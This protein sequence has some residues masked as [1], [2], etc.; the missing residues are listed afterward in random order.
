MAGN[1]CVVFVYLTVVLFCHLFILFVQGSACLC[2][3]NLFIKFQ[4]LENGPDSNRIICLQMLVDCPLPIMP[5]LTLT[6]TFHSFLSRM[7][8]FY[9]RYICCDISSE[10]LLFIASC[11]CIYIESM[12]LDI[13]VLWFRYVS[14]CFVF[15]LFSFLRKLEYIPD[16][17]SYYFFELSIIHK[18]CD[19]SNQLSVIFCHSSSAFNTILFIWHLFVLWYN[20]REI[21]MKLLQ[22]CDVENLWFLF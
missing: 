13:D 15:S 19:Q 3:A 22:I 8:Y 20:F 21:D 2:I 17:A 1:T 7:S 10:K 9:D 5:S 4:Y 18:I 6:V 11:T 12:E 14:F 16:I